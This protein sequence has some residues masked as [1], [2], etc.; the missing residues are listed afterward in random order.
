MVLTQSK[1]LGAK[2]KATFSSCVGSA[3]YLSQDRA[4]VKFAVK[5]FARQIRTPRTCDWQNLKILARYLQGA[6]S[7]GHM[8]KIAE[9]VDVQDA[10]PLHAFCD[11][12]WAGDKES[13]KSTSGEIIFLA[14]TAVDSDLIRKQELRLQ[15]QVKQN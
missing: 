12:D 4:D 11:S 6:R 14:G 2:D 13:R 1:E 7:L 9:D 8:T 15:A 3:I 10:L 5:E